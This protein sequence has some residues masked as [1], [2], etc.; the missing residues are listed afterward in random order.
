MKRVFL[1]ALMFTAIFSIGAKEIQTKESILAEIQSN[2]KLIESGSTNVHALLDDLKSE[3]AL[4]DMDENKHLKGEEI[5]LFINAKVM[6]R[7]AKDAQSLVAELEEDVKSLETATDKN[8]ILAKIKGFTQLLEIYESILDKEQKDVLYS[9]RIVAYNDWLANNSKGTYSEEGLKKELLEYLKTKRFGD[10]KHNND[11]DAL[12]TYALDKITG[13]FQT[14]KLLGNDISML[15]ELFPYYV[16]KIEKLHDS[17]QV[18]GSQELQ[19][20]I[21]TVIEIQYMILKGIEVKGKN[22]ESPTYH[23]E[24]YENFSNFVEYCDRLLKV[25]YVTQPGKWVMIDGGKKDYIDA[26]ERTS[27]IIKGLRI[28]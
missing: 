11:L 10:E 2:L 27:E 26:I 8:L 18:F 12:A 13:Y 6:L 23:L 1:I 17:K 15:I 20:L 5:V 7:K 19:P 28:K 4:L 24:N 22:N 25:I 14:S 9:A 3:I 21:N 16:E